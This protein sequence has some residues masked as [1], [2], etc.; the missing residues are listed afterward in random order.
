[1]PFLALVFALICRGQPWL[2]TEHLPLFITG[3]V[4]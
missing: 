1:M 3:Y 2:M 4:D